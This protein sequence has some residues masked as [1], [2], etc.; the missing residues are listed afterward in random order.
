MSVLTP[1][2]QFETSK[3]TR[4]SLD[5]CFLFESSW[6]KAVLETQKMRKEYTT[7]FGL[8]E[9]KECVKMPYLPGLQSCQKS[10]SSSP[11]DIHKRLLHADSEMP[12]ISHSSENIS[13]CLQVFYSPLHIAQR[14]VKEQP[15]Q[16]RIKKTKEAC[17]VVPLQE[18]SK[19]LLRHSNSS[20]SFGLLNAW[21][22]VVLFPAGL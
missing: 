20:V 11:L 6:R 2:I 4:S 17:T 7:A 3:V 13:S 15:W 1:G 14:P 9:L 12:S 10:L 18:K 21:N 8:E 5:S 16:S 19:G 22:L